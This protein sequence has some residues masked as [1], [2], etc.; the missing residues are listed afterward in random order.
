MKHKYSLTRVNFQVAEKLGSIK[1]H[2]RENETVQ[3][4]HE[5]IS[6]LWW[7]PLGLQKCDSGSLGMG[8][9]DL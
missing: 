1:C 4:A 8:E 7:R 5:V 6:E 3:G 9:I 2:I